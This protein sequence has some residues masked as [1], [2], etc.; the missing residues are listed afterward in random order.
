MSNLG[1]IGVGIM[2]RPMAGHLM[3]AGHK[4]F[5]WGRNKL[6][7]DLLDKDAVRCGSPKEVAQKADIVFTMVSDTPDVEQVLFSEN[8]VAKGLS[9]GKIVIDM[10]SISP[11]ATK[12]FA[13][14]IEALGCSYVDAPV[15]GGEV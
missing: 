10:S 6:P 9:P 7:Q 11:L 5:L 2:G 14:R 15:S 4:M 13:K 12:D 8:G 1:F 3:A